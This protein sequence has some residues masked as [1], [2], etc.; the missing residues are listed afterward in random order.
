MAKKI[1]TFNNDKISTRSGT[2]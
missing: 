2:Q 1:M